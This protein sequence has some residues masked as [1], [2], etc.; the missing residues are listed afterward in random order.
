[1]TKRIIAAGVSIIL[2]SDLH[3]PA[4]HSRGYFS[5]RSCIRAL[6]ALIAVVNDEQPDEVWVLGDFFH[7]S[8][9]QQDYHGE[10]LQQ[11]QTSIGAHIVIMT[12]NHDK[13]LL[14]QFAQIA[15]V[16]NLEIVC[17]PFVTLY[18]A[19]PLQ[20]WPT[21]TDTCGKQATCLP[22]RLIVPAVWLTHDGGQPLWLSE[23]Q[24][25][26]YLQQLRTQWEI[27]PTDMLVTGH[28]HH[29]IVCDEGRTRSLGVW[30]IPG[31]G[32]NQ[33]SL[34]AKVIANVHGFDVQCVR[35]SR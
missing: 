21:Q 34:Y 8:A 31:H 23:A 33:T 15:S 32:E 20:E 11:F 5:S 29:V 6:D 27:P 4:P 22:E 14:Q 26:P 2:V 12:G 1:M 24:C 17:T 19:K 25:V 30:N 18:P 9:Y 3:M 13:H 35:H 28:T 7:M 16:P 10:Q